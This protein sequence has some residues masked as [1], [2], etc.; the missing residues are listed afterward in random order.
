[1]NAMISE[2]L[3]KSEILTINDFLE[4]Y[5]ILTSYNIKNGVVLDYNFGLGNRS[6]KILPV[7]QLAQPKHAKYISKIFKEVYHGTYPFR[8]FENEREI[9]FMIKN[10]NYFLLIFKT[11]ENKIVGCVGAKLNFKEK[12][13]YIFGYVIKK[14]FQGKF[15]IKKSWIGSLVFIWKLFKNRILIWTSEVRTFCKTPQFCDSFVGLKP[16][17]FLPNKDIFNNRIESEF[18]T[19]IYDELVMN[20]YRGKFIPKLIRQ[21]LNYYYYS[22]RR[23][24][25]GKILIEN[26]NLKLNKKLILELKNKLTIRTESDKFGIKFIKFSYNKQG[27]YFQ[28]IYNSVSNNIEKITYRA[29]FLEELWTYVEQL[30]LFIKK[31]NIRYVECFISA[32]KPNHQKIFCNNGF[33]PRGYIPFFHYNIEKGWFEDVVLFNY[34]KGKIDSNLKYNLIPETINLY[35]SSK[36]RIII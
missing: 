25:I 17:A 3:V 28:F 5:D 14:E 7:I 9:E 8:R 29:N 10:P 1:M 12:N 23:Y 15:D 27:S 36:N 6:H 21:V 24:N 16:I 13:G 30:K 11:I 35:Y 33:K 31:Y 22:N 4:K 19:I 20:K 18:F 34:Y 32:Y 26:P 2:R